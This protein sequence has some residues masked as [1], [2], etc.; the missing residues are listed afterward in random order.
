MF[1]AE[2]RKYV[3]VKTPDGYRPKDIEMVQRSESQ[4]VIK[5]LNEGQ[6]VAMANPEESQKKAAGGGAMSALGKK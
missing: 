6:L 4:V 2:G 1:E 5:G 3:Y